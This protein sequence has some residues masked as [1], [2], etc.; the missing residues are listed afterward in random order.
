MTNTRYFICTD[1]SGHTY[2]VPLEKAEAWGA[3]RKIGEEDEDDPRG[4]ETPKYATPI[5][6]PYSITFT[7][8]DPI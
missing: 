7:D 2:L 8:P 5:S 6:N 4:W 1:C 3:W